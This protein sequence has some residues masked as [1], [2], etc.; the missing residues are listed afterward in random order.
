[1]KKIAL[2]CAAGMS[3]SVLVQKMENA[4]KEMEF[5]CEIAAYPV[6]T[7]LEVGKDADV[8]LL[9]PQVR[10]ELNKVKELCPNCPVDVIDMV[11]Y[12]TMNG[13]KVIERAKELMGC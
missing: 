2:L 6:S 5:E 8:I 12:G 10:F 7:A 13:K 9:G 3:T 11:A 4:A 1:M